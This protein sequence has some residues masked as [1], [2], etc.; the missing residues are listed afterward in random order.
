MFVNQSTRYP[1]STLITDYTL[2]RIVKE[3]FDGLM[4]PHPPLQLSR[5]VAGRAD[6]FVRK[7]LV[8]SIEIINFG[9]SKPNSQSERVNCDNTDGERL[10]PMWRGR[11]RLVMMC[12]LYIHV[13]GCNIV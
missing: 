5:T 13:D 7:L 11:D 1:V 2:C 12:V 9:N 8:V 10:Y 3:E 6:N 4:L